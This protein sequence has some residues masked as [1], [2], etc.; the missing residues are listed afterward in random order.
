MD[1]I[2]K[3]PTK[4]FYGE[5]TLAGKKYFT[6]LYTDIAISSSCVDCHNN[7]KDSAKKDFKVGDVMGLY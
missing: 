6:A 3:N 2:L 1:F 4:N 5:K 7:H